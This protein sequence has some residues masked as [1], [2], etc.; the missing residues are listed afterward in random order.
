MALSLSGI[1]SSSR[2]YGAETLTVV[3]RGDDDLGDPREVTTRYNDD[4]SW[5]DEIE[6]FARAIIA[7]REIR[8]GSSLEALKT[9]QL[10]FDIYAADREW[11][12]R[13]L[14][15]TPVLQGAAR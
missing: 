5:R 3:Y 11:A 14:T 9:M 8:H 15:P 12:E 4:Q 6:E 13:W 1:L 10:V 2:S 7:N